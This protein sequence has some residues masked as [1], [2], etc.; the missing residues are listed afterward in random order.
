MPSSTRPSA[1]STA[2]VPERRPVRES[3]SSGARARAVRSDLVDPT[4]AGATGRQRIQPRT[5]DGECFVGE[6][7]DLH[8]DAGLPEAGGSALTP[9]SRIDHRDQQARDAGVEEC[10]VAR[11]SAAVVVAGLQGDNVYVEFCDVISG[12]GRKPGTGADW[13]LEMLPVVTVTSAC[14]GEQRESLL[15][16]AVRTAAVCFRT[17]PARRPRLPK[18]TPAPKIVIHQV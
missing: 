6:E 10:L 2:S 17:A 12:A 15:R 8:L 4:D 18:R 9:G 11:G 5:E 3:S 7:A 14:L 1:W 16:R 13:A